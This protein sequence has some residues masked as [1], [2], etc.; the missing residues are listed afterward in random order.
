MTVEE[1]DIFLIGYR[2]FEKYIEINPLKNKK[3]YIGKLFDVDEDNLKSTFYIHDIHYKKVKYLW[4]KNIL[5]KLSFH[6]YSSFKQVEFVEV[7]CRNIEK[8]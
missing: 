8:G 2:G 5:Y 6:K 4:L 7:E 1:G 3:L